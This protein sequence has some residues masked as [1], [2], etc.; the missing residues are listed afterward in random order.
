METVKPW[1]YKPRKSR[2]GLDDG[3]KKGKRYNS[4]HWSPEENLKY[5][6]FLKVYSDL[7]NGDTLQKRKYHLN[8]MLS[9]HIGSRSPVQCRSHH[10]KMM[11]AFQTPEAI[12]AHF[13]QQDDESAKPSSHTDE[14]VSYS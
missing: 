14:P 1:F 11:K 9:K 12:I 5:V 8:R 2:F 4:L 13:Y 7:V 6:D 3:P 10:Q